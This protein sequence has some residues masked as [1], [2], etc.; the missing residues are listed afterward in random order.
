MMHPASICRKSVEALRV[1]GLLQT[2]DKKNV[3][4]PCSVSMEDANKKFRDIKEV[5][6]YLRFTKT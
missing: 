2:V 4:I 5:K 6:T 1:I 3:I